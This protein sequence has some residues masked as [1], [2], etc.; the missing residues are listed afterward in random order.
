MGKELTTS[1]SKTVDYYDQTAN[2]WTESHSTPKFWGPVEK[3]YQLV[4]AGRVLEIG[5]GGGRDAQDY[6]IDRFDYTG[7]D[8]SEGLL[9]EARKRNPDG[10]F[11]KESVY[12]LD[13]PDDS[14]DGFW[15]AAVLLHMPKDRIGKALTRIHSVVKS[16]GGGFVSVKQGEGERE[17]E[18]GR[19]FAYYSQDE[20][21]KVLSGNGFEV[22]E[23]DVLKTSNTTWL[24]YAVRCEK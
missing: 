12:E 16:G 22:V 2:S 15:A 14:F 24:V 23:S 19:W 3:F 9:A 13:F 10:K 1:E 18:T 8:M 6:L 5:C 4:T 7:V 11:F 21:C 17:D 20:F